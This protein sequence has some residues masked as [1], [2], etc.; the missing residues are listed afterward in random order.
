MERGVFNLL[1]FKTLPSTRLRPSR[2]ESDRR[3][4]LCLLRRFRRK[5]LQLLQLIGRP[6]KQLIWVNVVEKPTIVGFSFRAQACFFFL[7]TV[8]Q[9]I[10]SSSQ[11]LCTVGEII[12]IKEEQQVVLTLDLGKSDICFDQKC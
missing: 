2:S 11:Y 3:W 12:N 9:L 1:E 7:Y 8:N 6:F 5:L 4:H 10:K